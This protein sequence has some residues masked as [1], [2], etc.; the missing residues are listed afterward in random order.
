MFLSIATSL[1]TGALC[2]LVS[3]DRGLPVDTSVASMLRSEDPVNSKD[4]SF[5][6]HNVRHAVSWHRT[7][8]NRRHV[9]L[10]SSR[11]QTSTCFWGWGGV[12]VGRW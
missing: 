2:A 9:S 6:K 11:S 3:L 7:V 4:P 12:R 1:L 8:F 5:T 10:W